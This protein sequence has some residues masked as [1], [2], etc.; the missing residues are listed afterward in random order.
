MIIIYSSHSTL[1]HIVQFS[2]RLDESSER[3]AD[4]VKQA[5]MLS[6]NTKKELESLASEHEK[7]LKALEEKYKAEMDKLEAGDDKLVSVL[8][9]DAAAEKAKLVATLENKKKA[10]DAERNKKTDSL[11]VGFKMGTSFVLYGI[12]SYDINYCTGPTSSQT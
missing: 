6:D 3:G 12:F 7:K 5:T 8:E 2:S 4:E 9:R 1:F 11:K 10:L